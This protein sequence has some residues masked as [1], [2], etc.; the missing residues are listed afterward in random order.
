M[1]TFKN[2][3]IFYPEENCKKGGE[4]A[5]GNVVLFQNIQHQILTSMQN[6]IK[7]SIM[8]NNLRSHE[9]LQHN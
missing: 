5:Q 6:A 4:N 8:L 2:C 7:N 3:I 1:N 9:I